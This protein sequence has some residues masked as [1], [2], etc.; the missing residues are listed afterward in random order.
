MIPKKRKGKSASAGN[1]IRSKNQNLVALHS[2]KVYY[3]MVLGNNK[4]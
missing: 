4:L 3:F 2:Y 1:V